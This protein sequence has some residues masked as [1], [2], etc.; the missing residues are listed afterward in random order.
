MGKSQLWR[1]KGRSEV[2]CRLEDGEQALP[3]PERTQPPRGS[4]EPGSGWPAAPSPTALHRRDTPSLQE[5]AGNEANPPPEL[6]RPEG[7][8]GGT[9]AGQLGAPRLTTW[10]HFL[11]DTCGCSVAVML[12]DSLV[13]P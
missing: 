9:Q 5:E 7:G 2:A 12:S 10:P 6:T 3:D 4:R 8:W 13:I 1:Q 11:T